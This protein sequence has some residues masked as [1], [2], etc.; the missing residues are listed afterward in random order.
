MEDF[1]S[2]WL[3]R[4]GSIVNRAYLSS[5][6]SLFIAAVH[7]TSESPD[8]AYAYRFMIEL[9]GNSYLWRTILV[10]GRTVKLISEHDLVAFYFSVASYFIV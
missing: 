2:P 1:L 9:V 8:G 5:R 4:R 10:H 6:A 3:R 7:T